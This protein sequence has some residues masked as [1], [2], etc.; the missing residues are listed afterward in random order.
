MVKCPVCDSERVWKV[1]TVPTQKQG[2]R[3]RYKC[4]LCAK[5]FYVDGLLLRGLKE[6]A[7]GKVKYKGSFARYA[8][9][10]Q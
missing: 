6:S 9:E 4:A 7:E 3:Q 10:E 2:Q 1:G 8:K 5:T